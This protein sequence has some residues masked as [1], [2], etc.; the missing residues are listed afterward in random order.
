MVAAVGLSKASA[1]QTVAAL[2]PHPNI[3]LACHGSQA[4]NLMWVIA[5]LFSFA[6]QCST[7]EPWNNAAEKCVDQWAM[8]KAIWGTSIITDMVIIVLPSILMLKVQISSKQRWVI[9]ALF[10]SRIM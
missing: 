8:Q 4:M 6:F 2:R 9:A 3:L 7:P 5:G 1:I 10:G